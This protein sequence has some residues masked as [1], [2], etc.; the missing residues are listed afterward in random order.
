MIGR[1]W[2]GWTPIP[3]GPSAGRGPTV[4]QSRLTDVCLP[5]M[6]ADSVPLKS[7]FVKDIRYVVPLYQRPYVWTEE[8]KWEPLWRDILTL[9]EDLRG[10]VAGSLPAPH[11]LGAI[12]LDAKWGMTADLEV[13]HII[14]GQQRLVTLQLLLSAGAATAR[15]AGAQQAAHILSALTQNDSNLWTDEDHRFKV[16]PTNVDRSAYRAAMSGE[17]LPTQDGERVW[18]AHQYFVRA[19]TDWAHASNADPEESFRLLARALRE[20]VRLVV[21]DLEADDNAQ[22]IFETLNART[23]P[24]LAIDLVKNLVFRRA[25][26]E[27]ANLDSLH[28][29]YWAPFDEVHWRRESRQGRLRLPR[30][31]IFLAH[32]LAMKTRQEIS[33]SRLYAGF[34]RVLDAADEPAAERTAEEFHSDSLVYDSFEHQ[35]PGTREWVFFRRLGALDVGTVYP[36]ALLLFRQDPEVLSCAR[37]TRA[38]EALESWLVRRALCR[39]SIKNY[40]RFFADLVAELA[41]DVPASDEVLVAALRRGAGPTTKWP[42]DADLDEAL[43]EHPLYW[44]VAGPKIVMVLSAIEEDLRDPKKTE[45]VP[46]PDSLTIEH[47]LPQRWR[48]HWPVSAGDGAAEA[49]R[50]AHVNRLGNLT[51][52][53]HALNPGMSNRSWPEKRLELGNSL[54]ALNVNLVRDHPD[55]WD[56]GTIDQRS[57]ALARRVCRIWPGPSAERWTEIN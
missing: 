40:N 25:E 54:L 28:H 1:G 22:V 48:E 23:T 16:W 18:K 39:M 9:V 41:R 17:S 38:L 3:L 19:I 8:D 26:L 37:R 14:D 45:A 11:F 47:I 52:V 24:L 50:E 36:M 35:L 10:Q 29:D 43:V 32:W 5:A 46:L 7:L 33:P 31:E 27:S 34:Q 13:R 57:I 53:T 42:S 30:A 51:L 21:I 12:V 56:E 4:A 2:S 55:R 15:Q 44:N 20:C 49:T 6:R